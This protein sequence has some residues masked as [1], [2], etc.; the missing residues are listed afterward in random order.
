M[1]DF[2]ADGEYSFNA[3]FYYDYPG[4]LV[5]QLL[6]VQMQGQELEISVDGERVGVIKIDPDVKE[7][8][9][10]YVTPKVRIAAGQRRLAAAFVSKF[11]G[12]VQDHY[13]LIEQTLLDT[14]ITSS[15]N[16][17]GLPHLQ[18]FSVTGPFNATGVSDSR[19]RKKILTC[20]P[21]S[22]AD[23][24]PCA[25]QIIGE[26]AAKAFRRPSTPE[27]LE[28]LLGYYNAGRKDRDFDSGIRAAIQAILAK[29]EFLFRFEQEP[30]GSRPG[31]TYQ[32]SDLE[33]ATRL[34]YFMWSTLPDAELVRVASA[35]QLK[36]PSVLEAQVKRMLADPRSEA[37]ARNFA[38]QWLRLAGLQQVF[39]EALLFPNFTLNLAQSMRREVEL[40]FH[41]LMR[42]DKSVL[43]LMTADYTFVDEVLARH[44]GIPN[45]VG[46]RFKRVQ[47]TEPERFGLL[48][49][50]GILTMTSMANRTSPVAR[51][52][53]ILEVLTGT[54]PPPPPPLVPPLKESV[55]NQVVH[56]VRARME[57]HRNNPAC[58]SCHQIMDPIGMAMENFDAV[59]V[60]RRND[61]GQRVDPSGEMFDGTR[62]DGPLSVRRAVLD[63]SELFLGTFTRNLLAYSVG[64]VLDDRDMPTVRMIQ[65]HA[66]QQ[67]NRFSA[68]LLGIVTSPPFRMREVA[69]SVDAAQVQR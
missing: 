9:A 67:Q 46:P 32:I 37:L 29:P 34:A 41:S 33:L 63:R 38:G 15:P 54:P 2:P 6:P 1:H 51:G 11:D 61:G 14:T 43:D 58:L 13:R 31:S 7:E 22:P 47:L 42:E 60:W 69:A 4:E 36:D 25:S 21:A 17:T 68:Y 49:K 64:R 20:R 24:Q 53:Y 10:N 45:I 23:E 39:P 35:G 66:M 44:Y 27:D 40:L 52:K 62:L 59:G 50:A 8:A 48:G 57:Q 3:I 30:A 5:G 55:D 18:S 19:S 65:K 16:I 56:S 28:G 12:P 26:L